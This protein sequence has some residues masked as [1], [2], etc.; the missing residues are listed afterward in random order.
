MESSETWE[1]TSLILKRS[2]YQVKVN[3][4]EYAVIEEK[5]SP[6]IYIKVP[7][8]QS[9]QFVLICSDGTTLPFSTSGASQAYNTDDGI[10]LRDVI[11]LTMRYFQSKAVDGKRKGRA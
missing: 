4:T 8:G 1:E 7:N 10:R 5:Y 2:G 11:V 9:T 3:S 6:D